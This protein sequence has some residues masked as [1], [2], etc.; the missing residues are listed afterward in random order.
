M[1]GTCVKVH[2]LWHSCG[3]YIWY[4]MYVG[5]HMLWHVCGGTNA[6]ACVWRYMCCDTC[7]TVR[8]QLMG[9]CH[10]PYVMWVPGLIHRVP[11]LVAGASTPWALH[12]VTL[13]MR[14]PGSHL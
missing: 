12:C 6:T 10:S 11:V 2:M 14:C 1:L 5:V 3:M 9:D 8:G 13:V 7:V 4:G